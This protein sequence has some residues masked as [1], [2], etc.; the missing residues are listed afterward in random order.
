MQHL[1]GTSLLHLVHVPKVHLYGSI[2]QN[3]LPLQDEQY[4]AM[5]MYCN[6]LELPPCYRC[7]ERGCPHSSSW[8]CFPFFCVCTQKW[9]GWVT[10]QFQFCFWSLAIIFS[11]EAVLLHSHHQCAS[12]SVSLHPCQHLPFS[13][14][15]ECEA[16]LHFQLEP[17]HQPFFYDGFFWDRVLR[18][19]CPGWLRTVILL[20]SASWAARI[21]AWATS[22]QP[23][24]LFMLIGHLCILFGEMELSPLCCFVLGCLFSLLLTFRNSL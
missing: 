19:I 23:W 4:S 17:P 21:Q 7:C 15:F 6:L 16:V 2:Y 5:C 20:I 13:E 8:R 24:A 3:F 22:T 1:S 18:T 12:A 14:G 10:W 9:K 11:R